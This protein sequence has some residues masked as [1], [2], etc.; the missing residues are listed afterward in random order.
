MTSSDDEDDASDTKFANID[1]SLKEAE[2]SHTF[3]KEK[4][5]IYLAEKSI[6][7]KKVIIPFFF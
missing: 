2:R 7:D 6:A 1:Q 3:Y 5:H 4:T